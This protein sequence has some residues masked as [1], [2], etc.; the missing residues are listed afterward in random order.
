MPRF[1]LQL[2]HQHHGGGAVIDARGI[3]RG[4]RAFLIEGR[5][6]LADA[7]ERDAV[8]GIF[9]G[10]DDDIALAAFHG[11]WDDFVLELPAFCAAS[12]FCCE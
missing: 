6:Q 2:F 8:L 3:G 1:R 9:V 4:H 12:A 7:F 10:I 5:P 11:H